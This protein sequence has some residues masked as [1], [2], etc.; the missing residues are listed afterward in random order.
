ML[1]SARRHH[2]L[3]KEPRDAIIR[4][5][6]MTTIDLPRVLESLKGRFRPGAV[7]RKTTYYLSLGEAP[8]EKWNVTLTPTGCEVAQGKIDKADCVL[9]MSA[10]LFVSLVEGRWKPGAMDL[11]S[12]KI[13][14][15]EIE[16]LKRLQTSFGLGET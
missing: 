12:G 10:P 6:R 11:L 3:P 15:N 5:R 7:D 16:L 13:K 14:T 2:S 9:K 4:E 8:G 1:S